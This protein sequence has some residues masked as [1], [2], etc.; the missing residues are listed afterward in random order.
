MNMNQT[1]SYDLI[2]DHLQ[3]DLIFDMTDELF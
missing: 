2:T 3:L 1:Y